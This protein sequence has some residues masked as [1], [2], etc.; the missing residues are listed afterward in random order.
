[1][2]IHT[3]LHPWDDIDKL[4]VIIKKGRGLSSIEDSVNVSIRG[5]KEKGTRN[6]KVTRKSTDS[7]EINRTKIN[8]KKKWQEKQLYGYLKRQTDEL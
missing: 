4:Y 1:M 5:R 7:I 3:D 6:T 8:T 2:M